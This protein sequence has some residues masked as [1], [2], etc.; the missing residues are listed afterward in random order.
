[1]MLVKEVMEKIETILDNN[2]ELKNDEISVET[3]REI[4]SLLSDFKNSN[5]DDLINNIRVKLN[6]IESELKE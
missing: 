2:N 4:K 3:Y 1:M 6:D 5:V